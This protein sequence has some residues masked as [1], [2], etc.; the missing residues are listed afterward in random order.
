M[1]RFTAEAT[2]AP[3]DSCKK[4]GSF[5]CFAETIKDDASAIGSGEAQAAALLQRQLREGKSRFNSS[6][7]RFTRLF[8]N[9]EIREARIRRRSRVED[10]T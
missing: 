3:S 2:L 10:R 1:A 9:F 7:L 8:M 4:R 5:I 6:R